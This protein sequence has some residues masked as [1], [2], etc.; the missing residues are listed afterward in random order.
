MATDIAGLFTTPDQY[1]LAQDQ[2]QQAQAMQFAQLDP[3]AQAQY[4]FYRGGQ[5]LGRAIGGALGGVDPQLQLISQRQQLA[6][7]LDPSKPESFMQAAQLAAQSGDQQFA[8]ALANSGR[9]AAIQVAQAN[10]ERQL[11]VPVDIQKIQMI[12]QINN[13]IAQYKAMPQTPEIQQ[14]ISNLESML[15]VINPKPKAE[16]TPNEIQI[17]QALAGEKG[18]KGTPE[19]NAEYSAQ[20]TRLT[21][22]E[23]KERNIA[24]GAEAER[25]SKATYGKSYADLTPEQAGLVD[26]AVEVSEQAKAKASAILL[27]G[28]PAAPKDWLAF[29]SQISKDPVMDRTSTI[30]A[31]APNAIETIRMSTTNDIAAAS[32]PGAL[33]RLTGEGKNMSDR[34]ISRYARTG[35]LTDRVAQDVVG[36]FTGQRTNVTKT[37]AE[38]FA[39]AVYRGALLERKKFIQDQAEQAGYKDTPNYAV[40]IR[41]LDDQLA[42]F[43]LVKP[44]EKNKPQSPEATPTFD[45]DKEKRYQEYKAKQSGVTR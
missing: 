3:R 37:Q 28:Q 24:F 31:D 22:K 5:Q 21:T 23:P 1:Q 34:D 45:A 15:S 20:L 30:I 27:P 4:G 39:T 12:P 40:A 7:Q 18:V 42:K 11:A 29:S 38:Q 35:G 32:L 26:K 36:F 41:Q 9:Q 17:A 10:K 13:A 33:A 44:G 14:Q 19:Y 43:K 8:I 2:A 25:K 6:A 16:A